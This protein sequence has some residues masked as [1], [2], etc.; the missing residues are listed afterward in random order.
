MRT[1]IFLSIL[2]T[3]ILP[4]LYLTL[5]PLTFNLR[6]RNLNWVLSFLILTLDYT[7]HLRFTYLEEEAPTMY[8]RY[9]ESPDGVFN[10]PLFATEEEANYYDEQ[11]GGAGTSHTHT[12]ADDPTNTTWYMPDTNG[13]MNGT[14]APSF[15][16]SLGQSATYTEITSLTNS[17]LAPPLFSANNITQEEGTNVNIQINPAG[18]NWSTSVSIHPTTSGLVWDGYSMVQGTLADVGSDTTYTITVTRGNSYGST[19]GSMTVTAT[20]VAPVQT[21]LTPWTKALDFS[22]SSERVV[23]VNPNTTYNALRMNGLSATV[24]GNANANYTT[25]FSTGRPWAT[26]IVFKADLNNS[27]QHIWNQW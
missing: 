10:Y 8:F 16:L 13:V 11:N 6:V 5:E 9:I 27:N 12:Y 3:L 2:T 7:L 20:D 26:A 4:L 19:T 15:D 21:N 24:G 23:Q 18:S 25:S 14:S 22:G 1:D 17:D